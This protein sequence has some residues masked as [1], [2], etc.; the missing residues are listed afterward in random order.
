MRRLERVARTGR[1]D[2][3][4]W[5]PDMKGRCQLRQLDTDVGNV[6][7]SLQE[8]RRELVHRSKFSPVSV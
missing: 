7:I 1:R 5:L 2:T 6:K 4:T 8:T 3:Y